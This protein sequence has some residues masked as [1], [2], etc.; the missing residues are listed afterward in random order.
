MQ[1]EIAAIQQR[2][3]TFLKKTETRFHE[4]L[5][6]TE[7]HC[8]LL[9]EQ[10]DYK[11]QSFLVS[12]GAIKSQLHEL[13]SGISNTWTGKV[14]PLLGEAEY[15]H[16][17][18]HDAG[19]NLEAKLRHKLELFEITLEGKAAEKVYNHTI[20]QFK[21]QFQ[22]SQCRAVNDIKGNYFRSHYISC[23]FCNTVNT[24]NPSTRMREIEWFCVNHLAAFRCLAEWKA[25]K[26]HDYEMH[27][28]RN[29]PPEF[30]TRRDQLFADYYKKYLQERIRI[31][32][33]WRESYENDLKHGLAT[34]SR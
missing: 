26:Q 16:W 25:Y 28:L 6:Q 23:T 1:T 9:I 32:P 12:W 30:Y 7:E 15:D 29:I 11:T 31:I 5:Q 22:C 2:W 20:A 10:E 19:C 24:Y 3:E 13:I 33:E 34:L 14:R 18:M 21:P 27:S 4:T 8:L 17:H